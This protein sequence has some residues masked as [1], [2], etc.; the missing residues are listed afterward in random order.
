MSVM[1]S[2]RMVRVRAWAWE[3][4]L[5]GESSRGNTIRGNDRTESL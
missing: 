4:L 1:I 3:T 2:L 5:I